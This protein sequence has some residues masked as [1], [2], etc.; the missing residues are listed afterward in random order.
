[1]VRWGGRAADRCR[2]PET[3]GAGGGTCETTRLTLCLWS[4]FLKMKRPSGIYAERPSHLGAGL[5][6]RFLE[7]K[8]C[9]SGSKP[10]AGSRVPV[11]EPIVQCLVLTGQREP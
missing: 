2:G 9:E 5:Y 1:M 6:S 7:T 8:V 10:Q 11:R 4:S 3:R